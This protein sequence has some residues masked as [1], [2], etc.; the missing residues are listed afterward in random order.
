MTDQKYLS[1]S[2]PSGAEKLTEKMREIELKAK[3]GEV[4]KQAAVGGFPYINLVGF[5][6]S[7]EAISLIPKP[8][9]LELKVLCFISAGEEVRIGAVNPGL[10]AI[11]EVLYQVEERTGAKG[12]VYLISAHSFETAVKLYDALPTIRTI[13]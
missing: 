7:P 2:T 1:V 12:A 8:Q 5:P 6:I 9:A 13:T 11:K 3:E 4:E 10:P